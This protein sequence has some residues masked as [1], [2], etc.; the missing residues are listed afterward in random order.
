MRGMRIGD[1]AT[2]D[3]GHVEPTSISHYNGLPRLY[4]S[5]S[6]NINADEITSTKIAREKVKQIEAEFPEL[7]FNEIDAPADYTQKSLNGVWQSL[8]EGVILTMIVMML[9]LHLWRN[10]VVVMVA[11]PTSIL[12]TFILMNA[13]GF[14]LDSMSL[15]G[16]SLIIGILVDD[17]IVVL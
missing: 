16:L 8:F 10:A 1:V 13:F 5:M 2:A 11:I 14:H 9:F 12:S 4:V 3:D 17:S 15:M 7:T 6:R